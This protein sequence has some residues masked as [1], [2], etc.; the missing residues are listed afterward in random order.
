M[1]I[2]KIGVILVN[3]EQCKKNK[4]AT[5]CRT[6]YTIYLHFPSVSRCRPH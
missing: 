5:K 1:K 2:E 6:R 4:E 3:F